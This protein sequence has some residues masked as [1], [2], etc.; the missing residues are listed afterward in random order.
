LVLVIYDTKFQKNGKQNKWGAYDTGAATVTLAYQAINLGIYSHQMGGIDF[1]KIKESY[2]IDD[3][4]EPIA[5]LAFGYLGAD[6]D[7]DTEYIDS[8]KKKRERR[9]PEEL[10]FENEWGHP[11]Y[12]QLKS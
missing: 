8:D 12:T 11:L 9:K 1:A 6:D 7:L 10:F 2:A 4:Y 3:R 5:G